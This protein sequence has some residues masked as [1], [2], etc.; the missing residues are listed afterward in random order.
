MAITKLRN[1]GITDD[2]VTTDKIAPATVASSDIA[3][4]TIASSNIAPGAITA[5]RISPAVT[6][7]VPAVTSDPPSP[8][9]NPGD[10]WIRKD[11]TANQLKG[12]LNVAGAFSA[13]SDSPYAGYGGAA[14]G[15]AAAGAMI[16]RYGGHPRTSGDNGARGYDHQSFDN[17]SWTQETNFPYPN[18]GAFF[19]G[20]TSAGVAGGGHGNPGGPNSPLGSYAA[21]TISYEWDGSAWGSSASLNVATSSNDS[22]HSPSQSD[23]IVA[24]G[25]GGSPTSPNNGATISAQTYNG[26]AWSDLGS[27]MPLA[28]RASGSTGPSSD[29]LVYGGS[30]AGPSMTA[31]TVSWNGSTWSVEN[32]MP[33]VRTEFGSSAIGSATGSAFAIAGNPSPTT[34]NTT[35]VWNGTSWNADATN[36]AATPATSGGRS[37]GGVGSTDATSAIIAGFN[38][39]TAKVSRFTGPG[40]GVVNLN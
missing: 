39:G 1:R 29:H 15:T 13:L 16:C 18:S 25:W 31:A 5:D 28:L 23:A 6:L 38:D 36:P 14:T 30:T 7:G 8:G 10:M 32:S 2:A 37:F 26:T 4:A 27:N 40:Y 21:T 17:T 22:T 12:W 24:G 34:Y 35:V 11:L 33:S 3:P 19:H 20:T 9:L